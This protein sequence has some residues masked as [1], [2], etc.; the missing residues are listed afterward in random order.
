MFYTPLDLV[1]KKGKSSLF[2][3]QGSYSKLVFLAEG[4]LEWYLPNGR[5]PILTC[6]DPRV[7]EV[8][9]IGFSSHNLNPNRYIV[10]CPAD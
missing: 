7:A 4:K 8:K 9:Y 6:K 1:V 5:S 3:L 2:D 10:D